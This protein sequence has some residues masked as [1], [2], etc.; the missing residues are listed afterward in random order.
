[1]DVVKEAVCSFFHQIR[2]LAAGRAL[3]DRKACIRKE[4]KRYAT[5]IY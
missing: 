5:N 2:K 3:P 4:G 1:M